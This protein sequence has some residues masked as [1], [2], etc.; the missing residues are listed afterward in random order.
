MASQIGQGK[1]WM[2]GSDK[3]SVPISLDLGGTAIRYRM[4]VLPE[5][6]GPER[7]LNWLQLLCRSQG[8]EVPDL[9]EAF[10]EKVIEAARA[11]RA[12]PN[13]LQD[14]AA[15]L[16]K[17]A[18]GIKKSRKALD[19]RNLEMKQKAFKESVQDLVDRGMTQKQLFQLI[20]DAI[21][22]GIHKS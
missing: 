19:R 12:D 15:A 6:A 7:I 22:E 14:L 3:V 8:N 13:Q 1:L 20:R 18:A 9:N 17:T 16:K 11:A 2:D 10:G 5:D 21:I 4:V